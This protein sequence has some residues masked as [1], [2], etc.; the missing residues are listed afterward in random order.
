MI[1]FFSLFRKKRTLDLRITRKKGWVTYKGGKC[2]KCGYDRCVQALT[3]HHVGE[4]RFWLTDGGG[5]VGDYGRGPRGKTKKEIRSELDRCILL[6][7]NCHQE[8][9][10][11]LWSLV[12]AQP[13]G[14]SSVN[15][16][17]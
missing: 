3:F 8:L 14:S 17:G 16:T 10:A 6:C 4:K 11:G 5:K 2:V 7:A 12:A 9:H 15:L 1:S 13:V